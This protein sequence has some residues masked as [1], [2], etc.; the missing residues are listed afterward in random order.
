VHLVDY[1]LLS[2][3]LG[4]EKNGVQLSQIMVRNTS[5]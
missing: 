1:K 4:A 2:K 3:E 5:S